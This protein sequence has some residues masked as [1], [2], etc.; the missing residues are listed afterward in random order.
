M[1]QELNWRSEE[2]VWRRDGSTPWSLCLRSAVCT[3]QRRLSWCQI[4]KKVKTK[5]VSYHLRMNIFSLLD[6]W[7]RFQQISKRPQT[8][9]ASTV[10]SHKGVWRRDKDKYPPTKYQRK[11]NITHKQGTTSAK[12]TEVLTKS[13]RNGAKYGEHAENWLKTRHRWGPRAARLGTETQSMKKNLKQDVKSQVNKQ[14]RALKQPRNPNRNSIA[15]IRSAE[16]KPWDQDQ[17]TCPSLCMLTRCHVVNRGATPWAADTPPPS[18][19]TWHQP[20]SA[21]RPQRY[22]RRWTP[23]MKTNMHSFWFLVHPS[24]SQWFCWFRVLFSPR[25]CEESCR[26]VIYLS[27]LRDAD[28][29]FFLA[30]QSVFVCLWTYIPP[31]CAWPILCLKEGRLGGPG[32]EERII[33]LGQT[34]PRWRPPRNAGKSTSGPISQSRTESSHL[35]V[36]HLPA[37]HSAS[38]HMLGSL[39]ATVTLPSTHTPEIIV[40]NLENTDDQTSSYLCLRF[41]HRRHS[42]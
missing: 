16:L 22:G 41:S 15:S 39:S 31:V 23:S 20:V 28:R 7:E 26:Q 29:W 14:P 4:F 38:S 30:S 12:Q 33:T 21:D 13:W 36:S 3:P 9:W 5:K 37:R 19:S 11:Q 10:V 42:A 25:L 27:F 2:Q 35:P 34:V 1:T 6:L 32:G 24:V 18:L 40:S 17:E 8:L